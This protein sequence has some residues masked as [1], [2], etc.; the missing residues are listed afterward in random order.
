MLQKA[1]L[2]T[3]NSTSNY[4][5]EFGRTIELWSI[6]KQRAPKFGAH[7]HYPTFGRNVWNTGF[8]L[9]RSSKKAFT[10]LLSELRR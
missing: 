4:K 6:P 9:D 8:R 5:N 10:T 2:I 1:M 7:C 3:V